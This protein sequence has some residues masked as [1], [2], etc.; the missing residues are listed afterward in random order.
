MQTVELTAEEMDV[1]RDVITH[2]I[3]DMNVEVFRTDRHDFKQMLKHRR[4]V[5]E[6][7]LVRLEPEHVP[8][9]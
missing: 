6:H 4:E 9:L 3:G 7:V 8:V 2:V 5:L 1:L